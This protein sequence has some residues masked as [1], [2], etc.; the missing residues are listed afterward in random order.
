MGFDLNEKIAG[1]IGTGRIGKIL[2]KILKGFGMKVIAFDTFQ[3]IDLSS[4]FDGRRAALIQVTRIGEQDALRKNF[5]LSRENRKQPCNDNNE[6][7]QIRCN[8]V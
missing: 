8:M 2:I 6:H 7:Q 1:I 3:D 4:K 5:K